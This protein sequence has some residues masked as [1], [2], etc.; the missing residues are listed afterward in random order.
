MAYVLSSKPGA[1]TVTLTGT[2]GGTDVSL[3]SV[4]TEYNIQG[5]TFNTSSCSIQTTGVS[6]INTGNVGAAANSLLVSAFGAN[7]LSGPWAAL[8]KIG[9][10]PNTWRIQPSGQY[11]AQT[12]ADEIVGSS[13]T[14]SNT[15]TLSSSADEVIAGI[16]AFTLPATGGTQRPHP[17]AMTDLLY[18]MMWR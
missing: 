6:S 13:G 8:T 9:S 7:N 4:I 5:A 3:A 17:F 12:Q 14:Y 11:S 18:P 16:L 15:F 1:N 10:S 2:T